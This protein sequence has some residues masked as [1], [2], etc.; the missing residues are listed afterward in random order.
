M[1]SRNGRWLWMLW[2]PSTG[3]SQSYYRKQDNNPFGSR[4]PQSLLNMKAET[5]FSMNGVLGL[6]SNAS[7]APWWDTSQKWRHVSGIIFGC[8]F[9]FTQPKLKNPT[10]PLFPGLFADSGHRQDWGWAQQSQG[11]DDPSTCSLLPAQVEASS[12]TLSRKQKVWKRQD[13]EHSMEHML[14]DLPAVT[15]WQSERSHSGLPYDPPITPCNRQKRSPDSLA[16]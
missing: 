11:I 12:P 5:W 1:L 16:S 6:S 10:L 8:F 4:Y 14:R 15:G 9:H 3:A 13:E 2:E 7:F